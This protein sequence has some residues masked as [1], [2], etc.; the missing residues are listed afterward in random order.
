MPAMKVF[1]TEQVARLL[2]LD[3]RED[4]WRIVKF[5]TSREYGL[6]PSISVATGSGSRRLYSMDDVYEIAMA[7]RLLETGLR[8]LVI[9]Q[10]I[11]KVRKSGDLKNRDP[12]FALGRQA[13][14]GKPLRDE[15]TQKLEFFQSFA[16]AR[17]YIHDAEDFHGHGWDWML[18]DFSLIF[19]K[20]NEQLNQMKLERK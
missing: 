1:T 6:N 19:R 14:I 11:R 9:G 15:R 4:A 8:P 10:I 2:G 16:E 13:H 18:V 3:P 5:A 12:Y 17:E 20:I 7:L